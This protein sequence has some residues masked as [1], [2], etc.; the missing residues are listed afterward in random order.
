[1]KEKISV[2]TL[3]KNNNNNNTINNCM[4]LSHFIYIQFFVTL[5]TAAARLCCLAVGCHFLLQGTFQTQQSN[6][7]LLCLL[8]WQASS[9]SLAPPVKPTVNNNSV[10][11]VLSRFNYVQLFATLWT[12]SHQTLLSM[13][14]SR[15]EILQWVPMLFSYFI[16]S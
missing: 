1:M 9:L 10:L 6:P 2:R 11:C 14:F 15:Q 4:M 3:P 16:F 13:G 7:R 8:Y 5:Q 12:V